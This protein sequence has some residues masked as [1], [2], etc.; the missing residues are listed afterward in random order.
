V[1]KFDKL[2]L[3]SNTSGTLG[4]LYIS[5]SLIIVVSDLY[6]DISSPGISERVLID[7]GLALPSFELTLNVLCLYSQVSLTYLWWK[8]PLAI[9]IGYILFNYSISL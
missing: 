2:V 5:R 8:V 6:R 4:L 7:L 1:D 9:D 3:S